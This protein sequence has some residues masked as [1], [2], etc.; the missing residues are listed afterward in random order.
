MNVVEE[1]FG[2]V[3]SIESLCEGLG[4]IRSDAR[5][6]KRQNG[7]HQTGCHNEHQK[8]RH[9]RGTHVISADPIAGRISC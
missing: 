4:L 2:V 6:K 9:H 3:L 7:Q 1:P 8:R 5:D